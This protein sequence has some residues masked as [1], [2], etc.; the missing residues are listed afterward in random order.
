M[1]K[2]PESL[3]LPPKEPEAPREGDRVIPHEVRE[4]V[5]HLLCPFC[6]SSTTFEKAKTICRSAICRYRIVETCCE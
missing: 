6:Q 5:P 4:C 1:K 3:F 2:L